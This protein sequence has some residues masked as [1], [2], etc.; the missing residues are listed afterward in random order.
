MLVSKV[1]SASLL[2]SRVKSKDWPKESGVDTETLGEM[3]S[4]VRGVNLPCWGWVKRDF[5]ALVSLTSFTPLFSSPSRK[6]R[7]SPFCLPDV[8]LLLLLLFY[9]AVS[10]W[11]NEK[12]GSALEKKK[13]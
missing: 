8:L 5:T 12:G 11:E 13:T 7:S 4:L 10:W 9:S 1:P 2:V 6:S 3:S